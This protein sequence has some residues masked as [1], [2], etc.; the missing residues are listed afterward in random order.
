M[1]PFSALRLALS[2]WVL[3]ACGASAQAQ[4]ISFS[5]G[6][7]RNPSGVQISLRGAPACAPARVWVEGRWET[8]VQQVWVEGCE[9]RVW[10]PA[11]FETH[12]DSCGRAVQVV[13]SA[14]RWALVRDPGRFEQREVR[15]WIPGYW[16]ESFP[17]Y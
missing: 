17:R 4:R 16:R 6:G 13:V 15:V 11:R 1:R 9:R 5:F 14:G 8:R 3:L 2:A 7:H 10:V 12:W